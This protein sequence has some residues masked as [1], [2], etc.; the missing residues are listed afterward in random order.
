MYVP[1]IVTLYNVTEDPDTLDIEYNITILDGVFLDRN[2]A[3]NI[4]KT[5][6]RDADSAT[7]FIPFSVDAYEPK[8]GIA[9]IA[10]TNM[11]VAGIAIAGVAERKKTF[12][13]PKAYMALEDKTGYWT[14]AP[15]GVSSAVDCFFV[16]GIV[17]SELGYN[18]LRE[19]VD[20]VYDISTVDTRDFGSADMQHWQVGGR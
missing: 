20:D 8:E 4:E 18:K 14:L 15:G 3:S 19:S 2:N 6:L 13:T 10:I 7:L 1:H 17:V 9:E 12:I 11:A 5:G 16:R